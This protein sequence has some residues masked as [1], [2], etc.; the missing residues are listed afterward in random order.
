M[1]SRVESGMFSQIPSLLQFR[2]TPSTAFSTL[3]AVSLGAAVV[4]M[5]WQGQK[6]SVSLCWMR[7]DTHSC[8]LSLDTWSLNWIMKSYCLDMIPVSNKVQA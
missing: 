2:P 8:L 1:S 5:D 4:G 7:N 6:V 3:A